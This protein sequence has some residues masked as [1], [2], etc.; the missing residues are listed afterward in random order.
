LPEGRYGRD[1]KVAAIAVGGP[2]E[3]APMTQTLDAQFADLKLQIDDLVPPDKLFH[4]RA[5]FDGLYASFPKEPEAKVQIYTS[6]IV[7][8]G[9]T[10]FNC[11]NGGTFFIAL[12]GIFEAIRGRQPCSRQSRRRLFRVDRPDHRGH[13]PPTQFLI[14]AWRFVSPRRTADHVTNVVQAF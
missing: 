4:R 13:N 9:R 1:R 7:H 10:N 2:T 8:K 5:L 12:Q 6:E 11:H 3:A 14:C